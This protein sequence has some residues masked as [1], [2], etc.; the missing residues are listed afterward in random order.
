MHLVIQTHRCYRC[1]FQNKK[2]SGHEIAQ[3]C[4]ARV[5]LRNRRESI[6]CNEQNETVRLKM[7]DLLSHN[8]DVGIFA[9]YIREQSLAHE[10]LRLKNARIEIADEDNRGT[11]Y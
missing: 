4:G 7:T 5:W 9:L 8:F 1:V 2:C 11:A 10:P 6:R 3:R